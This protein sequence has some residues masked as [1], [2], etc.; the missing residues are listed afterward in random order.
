MAT[1]QQIKAIYA[2]GQALGLVG[3]GHEDLLH[4]LVAAEYGSE[5]IRELPEQQADALIRRLREDC[6]PA[7]PV[8][9]SRAGAMSEGQIKKVWRQMYRLAACDTEPSVI[10]LGERLCGIIRREL[11]ISAAPRDPFRWLDYAHGRRL[12]EILKGYATTAENR[13]EREARG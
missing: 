2:L 10:S 7:A 4:S 1:P 11:H 13:K 9:P 3:S 8:L 12:I 6:R 5:S